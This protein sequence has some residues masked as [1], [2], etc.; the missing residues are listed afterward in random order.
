MLQIIPESKR[1][2][3]MFDCEDGSD[4]ANC[5][6]TDYIQNTNPEA[7]CDGITDCIDLSDESDCG[8]LY[9]QQMRFIQLTINVFSKM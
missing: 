6:C 1:C 2:D 7:I 9:K 5:T 3:K 8:K 4:E